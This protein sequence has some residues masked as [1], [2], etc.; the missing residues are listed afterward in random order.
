MPGLRG[1]DLDSDVIIDL[2]PCKS[3]KIAHAD[4][5]AGGNDAKLVVFSAKA[6][7]LS[8]END[9]RSAALSVLHVVLGTCRELRRI[10]DGT[11]WRQE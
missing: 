9:E 2:A 6:E 4:M 1:L 10:S 5:L 3:A 11:C 8:A 7:G